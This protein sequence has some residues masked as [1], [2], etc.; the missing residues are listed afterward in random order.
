M[1]PRPI[2]FVDHANDLGGAEQSLLLLMT[3]L[4]HSLWQPHLLAPPGK[5]AEEAAQ[6]D[7]P[8]HS[9]D[10]PRLRGSSRS[11]LDWWYAAASISRTAR[12]IGAALI[13]SNTVRATAY[14]ALAARLASLPL[15][16]HMQDFWLSESEPASKWPDR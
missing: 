6:A 14:A 4:D 13:H 5:L 16:W 8:V 10:L 2:L 15:V 9:L 12:R 7:I 1:T 3:F 11:L